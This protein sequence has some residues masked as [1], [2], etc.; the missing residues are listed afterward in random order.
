[1]EKYGT[2]E[3]ATDEKNNMA[4]EHCMLDNLGYTQTHLEY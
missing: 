4:H 2:A 1:M 3:E